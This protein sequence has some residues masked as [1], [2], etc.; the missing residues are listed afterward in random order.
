MYL[1]IYTDFKNIHYTR[2]TCPLINGH[3]N[4]LLNNENKSYKCENE[5]GVR[6]NAT[7]LGHMVTVGM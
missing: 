2:L 5:S 3:I 1:T 6:D 7:T 4:Y